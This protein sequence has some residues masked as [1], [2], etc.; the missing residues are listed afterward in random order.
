[1]VFFIW[2]KLA[3]ILACNIGCRHYDVYN[4]T[5]LWMAWFIKR[6]ESQRKTICT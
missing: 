3:P 2:I 4:I 5:F 6:V 1:M